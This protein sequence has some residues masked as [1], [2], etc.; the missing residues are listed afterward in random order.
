[1]SEDINNDFNNEVDTCSEEGCACGNCIEILDSTRRG[2]AFVRYV[3]DGEFDS[4][5]FEYFADNDNGNYDSNTCHVTR[6]FARRFLTYI[7]DEGH[8]VESTDNFYYHE[9]SCEWYTYPEEDTSMM[10]Y[11]DNHG[12]D[13][14]TAG[15]S[16]W[17]AGIEFE[18][19]TYEHRRNARE[20]LRNN[21]VRIEKDSSVTG[22]EFITGTVALDSLG[23]YLNNLSWLFFAEEIDEDCGGHF[24]LSHKA[25]TPSQVAFQV[26]GA[27]RLALLGALYPERRDNHFCEFEAPSFSKYTAFHLCGKNVG[28]R[29]E[30]RLFPGCDNLATAQWRVRLIEAITGGDAETIETTVFQDEASEFHLLSDDDQVD[31]FTTW[32]VLEKQLLDSSRWEG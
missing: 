32:L 24:N 15:D 8:W 29:F 2:V 1:M 11:H 28:D 27:S 20:I 7:Q 12:R 3:E 21:G 31:F 22:V 16:D 25:L 14:N 10:D 18:T 9:D 13:V 6:D 26:F 17:R 4:S 30:I 23:Q 19:S 5:D